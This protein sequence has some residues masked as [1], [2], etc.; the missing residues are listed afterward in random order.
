MILFLRFAFAFV[1]IAMLCVT[2]WASSV[3]ALWKTPREVATHP[4]FIATL[5][6]TY[7]AFLT[8]WLWL[9]WKERAWI[10][11]LAWLVAI[12]LL[13]NIAMAAYMLIQL[14]RLP[15]DAPLEPL[16]LRRNP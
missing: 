14:F 8:F 11:R 7:F 3:V 5:F 15:K 13:G 16:F 2:S 4:W 6:D 10:P 1:I 12:L 9:A